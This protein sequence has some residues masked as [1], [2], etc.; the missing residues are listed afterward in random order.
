MGEGGGKR[1]GRCEE[2]WAMVKLCR[3]GWGELQVTVSDQATRPARPAACY[4]PSSGPR[5]Y[6]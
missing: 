2:E 3:V 1:K 5:L 6:L 4:L